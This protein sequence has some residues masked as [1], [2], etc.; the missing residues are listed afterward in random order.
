M[1]HDASFGMN[2]MEQSAGKIRASWEK[3]AE[4]P[5]FDYL[6][7]GIILVLVT[8]VCKVAGTHFSLTDVA[9]LYLLPVLYAGTRV[10]LSVAIATSIVCVLAF[11]LLFVPPLYTLTV[12]NI[13][14]LITF[15][16]FLAVA[17]TTS[18]IASRLRGQVS[19]TQEVMSETRTLYE[20]SQQLAAIGDI[21]DFARTIVNEISDKIGS[22]T[23]LFLPDENGEIRLA[24]TST[25]LTPL[26][27]E[28]AEQ[29]VAAWTFEHR[30]EAGAGTDTLP[31]VRGLYLPLNTE[32]TTIGVLGI[33]FDDA[34][35]PEA[36]KKKRQFDAIAGLTGLA[37]NKLLLHLT[38]QHVL[39]L[40]ESEK[41][42]TALFNSVS[43]ELRTPLSS[44]LGAVGSLVDSEELYSS[45]ERRSL[46][47]T[48]NEGAL[49]MSRLIG[50]LLD[51]ARLEGGRVQLNEEWCDIQDII[52]VALAEFSEEW[53]IR[54]LKIDVQ[55]EL[56]LIRVDFGF[57]VQVLVNL[58]DNAVK[59]SPQGGEAEIAAYED[60][61]KVVLV[62]GDSGPGIADKEKPRIFEKF[63]RISGVHHIAGTGL[64]LSIC[65]G[66]VEAHKGVI[67][68]EDRPGG[69]ALFLISLPVAQLR[70]EDLLEKDQRDET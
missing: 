59:Y 29:A 50:N 56:P 3:L 63:Y 10:R 46:L 31:G 67:W 32:E 4:Y 47:E 70:T 1:K 57:L 16:A 13:H 36:L 39:D 9:M 58:L 53:K 52:G 35:K 18:I 66:I 44:I 14:Y 26:A 38:R 15:A 41:L 62:V 61:D 51:M 64:G 54:P 25:A 6:M 22:D 48:I 8:L 37:L 60:E 34:D 23:V 40:E 49:R 68:V 24:A 17:F 12:Q 45:E 5:G 20:L 55:S 65:K 21:T 19:E 11:D 2:R 7:I 30:R 33:K 42:R 27:T 43:H 69:G 28:K